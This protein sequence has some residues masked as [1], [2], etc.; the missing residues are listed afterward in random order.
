M[1][2]DYQVSTLPTIHSSLSRRVILFSL[3]HANSVLFLHSDEDFQVF[4]L[5]YAAISKPTGTRCASKSD[6]AIHQHWRELRD[7]SAAPSTS[8]VLLADAQ[9][10]S[11]PNETWLWKSSSSL[12]LAFV[13]RWSISM[14]S[15]RAEA[16]LPQQWIAVDDEFL[17][18]LSVDAVLVSTRMPQV[19]RVPADTWRK[20]PSRQVFEELI[21]GLPYYAQESEP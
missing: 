5:C 15:S 4:H 16:R 8:A 3:W 2:P 9:A 1:T 12:L 20:L 21:V 10:W 11:W 7:A 18:S 6:P 13:F 14:W 19:A 17:S